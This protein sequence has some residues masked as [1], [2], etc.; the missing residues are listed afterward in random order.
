MQ[1]SKLSEPRAAHSID[2]VMPGRTTAAG[3]GAGFVDVAG[4]IGGQRHV[5][6]VALVRAQIPRNEDG[7]LGELVV[8]PLPADERACGRCCC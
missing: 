8:K 6:I 3:E 4:V 2:E 1:A 7:Q 5:F